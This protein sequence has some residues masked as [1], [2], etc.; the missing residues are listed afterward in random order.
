MSPPSVFTR[1]WR[2]RDHSLEVSESPSGAKMH[3]LLNVAVVAVFF[4][5]LATGVHIADR[6]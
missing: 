5:V 2:R 4:F 1:P 6:F 3:A